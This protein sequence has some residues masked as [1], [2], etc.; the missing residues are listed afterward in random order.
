MDN[1]LLSKIFDPEYFFC[2]C[3]ESGWLNIV[4]GAVDCKAMIIEL[5]PNFQ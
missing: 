1:L 3:E 5:N 2:I 4:M